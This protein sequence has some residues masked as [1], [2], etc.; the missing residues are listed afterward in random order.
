MPVY[1][2]ECSECKH[3]TEE[4]RLVRDVDAPSSCVKCGGNMKRS[5]VLG[6][7]GIQTDENALWI[8]DQLREVLQDSDL[9]NAKL[10]KPIESRTDLKKHCKDNDIIGVLE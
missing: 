8:D 10:E 4:F 2:Y 6:H 3:V 5:I 1:D 7:G 9:V